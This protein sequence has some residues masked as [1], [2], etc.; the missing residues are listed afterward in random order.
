MNWGPEAQVREPEAGKMIAALVEACE[1]MGCE[2]I[3]DTARVYQLGQTEELIGRLLKQEGQPWSGKDIKIH[4][5]AAP[6]VSPLTADNVRKQLEASLEALQMDSVDVFYL[7]MPEINVDPEE[8]FGACNEL[9]KEGKFKEL[10][11]SNYAAWDVVRCHA[12]CEKHGWVVPTV[13]QGV[14]NALARGFNSEL[15]PAVRTLGMRVYVYN[16]LGGGLLTGRYTKLE[17]ILEAEDGRFSSKFDLV[18]ASVKHSFKGKASSAYRSRYAHEEMMKACQLLIDTCGK[19]NMVNKAFAWLRHSSYLSAPDGIIFGASKI[20]H[21]TANLDAFV[22]SEPLTSKE[23]DAFDEAA[24][25]AAP[26]QPGYARQY[27]NGFG[28]SEI[29]MQRFVLEK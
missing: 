2:A 28:G 23:S 22:H 6:Q 12:L 15:F 9:Y 27:G 17:D 5:K 4:T 10:G 20:H 3:I 21:C 1:K 24:R 26:A 25:L 18:P 14:F 16:P 19:D 29:Y 11:L 8:T 7:H 13:Y